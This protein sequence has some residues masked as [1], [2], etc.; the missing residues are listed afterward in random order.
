MNDKPPKFLGQRRALVGGSKMFLRQKKYGRK[1]I[2]WT[3]GSVGKPTWVWIFGKAR[4]YRMETCWGQGWVEWIEKAFFNIHPS[5]LGLEA[6]SPTSFW[7]CCALLSVR[8]LGMGCATS[9]SDSQVTHKSSWPKSLSLLCLQDMTLDDVCPLW[10]ILVLL[11][12]SK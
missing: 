7:F 4:G 12:F 2:E 1:Q 9:V 6:V 5:G 3:D 8:H 10:N 11:L